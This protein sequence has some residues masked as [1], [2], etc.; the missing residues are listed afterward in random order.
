[1]AS[2]HKLSRNILGPSDLK[3][4]EV[5]GQLKSGSSWVYRS[6]I[7]LTPLQFT[8]VNSIDVIVHNVI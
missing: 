2:V 7:K 6:T 1:M 4:S 5:G 3:L 8:G